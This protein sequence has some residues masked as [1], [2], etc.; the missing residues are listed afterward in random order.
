[1]NVRHIALIALLV[2]V[3]MRAMEENSSDDSDTELKEDECRFS[4]GSA[5]FYIPYPNRGQDI[6]LTMT[7]LKLLQEQRKT[8]EILTTIVTQLEISQSLSSRNLNSDIEEGTETKKP[9][10]D[11]QDE[12]SDSI[13][14]FLLKLIGKF[15]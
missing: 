3:T 11:H 5:H 15:F 2:G 6:S 14:T 13:G 12:K 1:M 10:P 7:V 4:P 9:A 8:N